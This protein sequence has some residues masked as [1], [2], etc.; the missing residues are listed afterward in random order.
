MTL[1]EAIKRYIDNAE[2]ERTHGSLQ[3]CKD[4]KQLAEWLKEL[5]QLR[6]QEPILDKIRTE[7]TKAIQ[8]D[9]IVSSDGMDEMII[10]F[11]DP[12]DVY[13]IIDKYT[14]ERMQLKLLTSTS[15]KERTHE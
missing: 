5:K 9:Y 8:E 13:E 14:A 4:F 2:H 10:P 3:G 6:E 12:D 15:Q 11:L 7:I 1:D